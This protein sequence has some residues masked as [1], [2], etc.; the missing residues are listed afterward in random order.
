MAR[1]LTAFIFFTSTTALS[2]WSNV[3]LAQASSAPAEAAKADDQP[4]LEEI[5]VQARRTSERQQDVPIAVSTV[6]S[7]RLSDAT[8]TSVADI[9]RLVP[10]LQ[11]AQSASGAQT[12]TIRGSF[13]AFSVD[14]AV[15]SYIDD[16]P[17]DPRTL[18]YDLYDLNSVQQLK[19]PQGTLFGRNSTGGALLFY[20]N[21][22]RLD[23][24]EGYVVGRY[25]NLNERRLEGA[26]SVPLSNTFAVRVAG[27]IERRDG[28]TSSVTVPGL[29][30]EN[31]HNDA[32]RAS[33]L[34]KPADWIEDSVQFSRYRVNE[35]RYANVAI[36]LAGPCT[37][38][39]TPAVSCLYQPP[40]N[41]ILGNGDLRAAFTRQQG[42]PSNQTVANDPTTDL[43]DRTSIQNTVTLNGS[44]ISLRNVT[45]YGESR[46]GYSRDFDGTPVDVSKLTT[47][48]KLKTFYTETS[49]FGRLFDD[50]LDWRAGAVYSQE[51]SNFLQI[52]D[53]FHQ[54]VS[55]SNPIITTA[56]TNF[57]STGVYGQLT[58]DLSDILKGVSVTAG[59]RYTWDDRR[60]TSQ[61]YQGTPTQVCSLQ[62][63]PVPATG[64]VPF[65]NTNLATCTR[66]LSAKFSD[67]NYN[68]T[69]Q[70]KPAD[71]VLL[72]A[73]TRKGYKTGSF[74]LFQS[75]P[76][77]SVYDPE[78][79]EDVEL[80]LK[81]DWRIGS[82]PIRTNVAAFRSNYTNIQAQVVIINPTSGAVDILVLNRDPAT[83]TP[84]KATIKGFEAEVNIVPTRWLEL[85]AFYSLLDSTYDQGIASGRNLAGQ[86]VANVIPVTYGI[87]AQVRLPLGTIAEETVL[88]ASYYRSAAPQTNIY[89]TSFPPGKSQV[90]ARI[91]FRRVFGTG[92]EFSIFGKNL[93]DN[94]YC[95]TNTVVSG[96]LTQTCSDPRTYG[97]ELGFRF[98]GR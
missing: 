62:T 13:S 21:K 66:T 94:V 15:I 47:D 81:A 5:V 83:G 87:N 22:P 2:G 10:S 54:P 82:V 64:P 9:Q 16:V 67:S 32:I 3:A 50:K 65:P 77:L 34:W 7:E 6:S 95:A 20:S 48:T 74:N 97:V 4:Q 17:I 18:V 73:A 60:A 12:F 89:S 85:A 39:T 41:T 38:P 40:F 51:K 61:I 56:D 80:G 84:T 96:E 49:V 93:T 28:L 75:A 46:I 69:L 26:V 24:A 31:R 76:A 33:A 58:Y 70:W 53:V 1:T 57:R 71:Q 8:V 30:F 92:A 36:Q 59:Y 86:K 72:Y 37:G 52:Y 44:A 68:F 14:P 55:T 90:D 23:A 19:G 63:L 27:E 79:V 29:Q 45:Y 98:G 42:L 91:R 25:G 78:V 88:S 43:V 35:H 11:V